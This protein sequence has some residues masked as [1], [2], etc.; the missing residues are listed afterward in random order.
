M[1]DDDL[2]AEEE[3]KLL[4]LKFAS[5]WKRLAAYVID[6]FILFVLLYAM[7]MIVYG[8]NLKYIQAMFVP[9]SPGETVEQIRQDNEKWKAALDSFSQTN[10]PVVLTV[11]VI[12]QFLYFTLFWTATGQTIGAKL[13]KIVV[14]DLT[15]SKLRFLQSLVRA[16]IFIFSCA[17][18]FYYLPFIFVFNPQYQQRIHD[19]FSRSVVVEMPELRRKDEKKDGEE[20]DAKP[21]A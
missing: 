13:L 16:G 8:E 19:F 1:Y 9:P 6:F 5:I 15:T 17:P 4:A 10:A 21:L 3:Q 2:Q 20:E 14:I 11:W 18:F 12:L 7:I